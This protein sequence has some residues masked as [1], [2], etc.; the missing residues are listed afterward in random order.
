MLVLDICLLVGLVIWICRAYERVRGL[1]VRPM[2][3]WEGYTVQQST[4]IVAEAERI[5]SEVQP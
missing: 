2:Q 4:G 3:L 5:V 1:P